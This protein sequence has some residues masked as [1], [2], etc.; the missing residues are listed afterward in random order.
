MLTVKVDD[1]LSDILSYGAAQPP[2]CSAGEVRVLVIGEKIF[3]VQEDFRPAATLD[4]CFVHPA[5]LYL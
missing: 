1:L 3:R 2:S 5:S 4:K